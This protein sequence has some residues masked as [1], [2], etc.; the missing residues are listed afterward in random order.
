MHYTL[1]Q[2]AANAFWYASNNRDTGGGVIISEG[3]EILQLYNLF[4]N[5]QHHHMPVLSEQLLVITSTSEPM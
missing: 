4:C 2:C 1:I 3:S 5:T